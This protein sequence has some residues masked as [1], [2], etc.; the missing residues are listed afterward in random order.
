MILHLAAGTGKSFAGCFMDSV[1]ATRNLLDAA[2]GEKG[3][4]RFLSVSSLA[5]HS[6]FRIRK[7]GLLDETSPI[8]RNHIS[9]F[10]PYAFGK[11]K[12]DELVASFGRTHGLPY[13][14]IRP[15]IIY[16]PGKRMIPG[17][18]GIDTFGVFL[19]LGGMN[20][21]PL[22]YI[23]NCAEAV[24]TAGIVAGVDGQVLIALDDELPR[25]RD[26]LRELKNNTGH[27]RSLKLPYGVFYRLNRM[28]EAYSRFSEGQLPP[29][30]NRR[31][32]ASYYQPQRY[33]NSK[34]KEMTGWEPRVPFAEAS[35]R[36]FEFM[37]NGASKR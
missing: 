5:V 29:L 8:E 17:R 28:W 35:R 25:S 15:G 18:L 4:K 1:V 37:R 3:L 24:V 11:I 20:R 16:G 34:L 13:V 10:D 22:I 26:F 23:D 31:Q 19:H 21:L 6:G 30:F 36:Y 9:R 33:S 14:I 32:C 7:G 27:F 2:V 12:Q